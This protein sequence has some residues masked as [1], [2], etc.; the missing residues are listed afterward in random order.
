MNARQNA[1]AWSRA[2]IQRDRD[3]FEKHCQNRAIERA[4]DRAHVELWE[5]VDGLAKTIGYERAVAIMV[6]DLR[7]VG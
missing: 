7:S 5:T 3:R 6:R 4:D 1:G 2:S